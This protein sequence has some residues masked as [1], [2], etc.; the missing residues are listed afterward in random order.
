MKKSLLFSGLI[1]AMTLLCCYALVTADVIHQ[2]RVATTHS[3]LQ[4]KAPAAAT[5]QKV[6]KAAVS[7]PRAGLLSGATKT[8]AL[9]VP[10]AEELDKSPI[11]TRPGSIPTEAILAAN[12]AAVEQAE[13]D[14]VAQKEYIEGLS[15]RIQELKDQGLFDAALWNEYYRAIAPEDQPAGRLDEGGETCATALGI[16]AL[17]YTDTGNTSDNVN[18]YDPGVLTTPNPPFNCPYS[19]STS[20]DVL[21]VYSPTSNICVD[22]NLCYT[23]TLYDTKLYV[24]QDNCGVTGSIVAC[25]DDAC[26]GYVSQI[27]GL[28]L[29]GGHNYYIVVDGYGYSAGAYKITVSQ[30]GGPQP[31]QTCANPVNVTLPPATWPYTNTNTTCGMVNDYSGSTTCLGIYD[32]GEDIIYKLT[33]TQAVTVILSLTSNSSYVG[34]CIDNSCPPDLTCLGLCTTYG[35]G[36]TINNV[37]LAVG[38]YYIMI[39]TWPSPTCIPQFTLTIDQSGGPQP[40]DECA[41][42]IVIPGGERLPYTDTKNTCLYGYTCGMSTAPDLFYKYTVQSP[43]EYLTISL[44]G[45]SYDTYLY[46]WSECCVT[47]LAFNDDY[48]GLQSQ[49]QGCYDP[50][51]IWIEVSGYSSNCG[52]AILNVTSAGPCPEAPPNDD[53]ADATA[54]TLPYVGDGTTAGATDDCAALAGYPSV[55]YTFTLPYACN[56][57]TIEYCNSPIVFN[58]YLI[59][60]TPDC[61]CSMFY[62]GAYAWSCADGNLINRFNGLAAGTYYLPVWVDPPGPFHI[63]IYNV[64]CPA[65]PECPPGSLFSQTPTDAAGAWSFYT[66]D[67]NTYPFWYMCFDNF[68]GLTSYVC[69]LHW[70]GL[71][72]VPIWYECTSENPMTFDI[73]FYQDAA[74][75]PGAQVAAFPGMSVVGQ[76]TGIF[77]SGYQMYYFSTTLTPCVGLAA[78]WVSIQGVSTGSPDCAFLWAN[79]PYG[80]LLSYQFD[81]ATMTNLMDDLAFC[82]TGE[83]ELIGACCD[84]STGDCQ[85][86]V[87]AAA[88]PPPSLFYANTLCAQLDPPCGMGACCDPVTGACT[89]TTQATCSGNWLAGVSCSPNPCPPPGDNCETALQVAVPSSTTGTTVGAD[90]T[91]GLS[92]MDV[93]YWFEMTECRNLTI[94]LCNSPDIYWDSYLMVYAGYGNCCYSYL[95]YDDDGCTPGYWGTSIIASRNYQPGIYYIQVDSYGIS[96]PFVL[97]IVDNGPCPAPP[98]NDLCS[99]AITLVVNDPNPTCGNNGGASGPDCPDYGFPDLWYTF[100]LTEACADLVIEWC[101]TTLSGSLYPYLYDNCDC[102]NAMWCTTYE[103][104]TCPDGLISL[105][106]ANLPAGTYYYPFNTDGVGDFCIRAACAGAPPPDNCMPCEA[107]I[108]MIGCV[109][110]HSYTTCDWNGLPQNCLVGCHPFELNCAGLQYLAGPKIFYMMNL[111]CQTTVDILCT[112]SPTMDPQLMVFTVCPTIGGIED[113]NSCVASSD[114]GAS[115][116]DGMP[117]RIITTIGPGVY[118]LSVDCYQNTGPFACGSYDLHVT[119]TDCPLPVELTTLEAIAGDREVALRWTTASEKDNAS[120]DVQRKT[121]SSEW[122]TVGKVNGVGNSQTPTNYAYTDRAVVNGVAYTYRLISRDINGTT[123]EF[124]TTVE[125]TPGAP[126]PTEYALNQNYPNPFNPQTSITYAVKEAGFVTLKVYNLIGQEVATLVSA[127]MEAGRYTAAFTATDLP[128]GV[129]VYRLEVNDFTAQKKMVLLK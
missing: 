125:A 17:P 39:D 59:V 32:G 110:D 112:P 90:N 103:W 66:S 27:M 10:K 6:D 47:Q 3:L 37:A 102:I 18:D 54:V 1:V 89:Q 2:K 82:L 15:Q 111:A 123:H 93:F 53:C 22:I 74:G 63:N 81:G 106:W 88:C 44:C 12:K 5:I 62:Y 33:V 127:K 129:Y 8:A 80:D 43:N 92:G 107:A 73:A 40:G 120:F 83:G 128:S 60:M 41:N 94:G 65:G 49:V 75:V 26:P 77:Y 14:K 97:D 21:Y 114:T 96:A 52:T 101:G 121:A 64:E 119:S 30:C 11:A 68:W 36:C 58:N 31:G 13:A 34:M 25:N 78:G 57:L 95:Y 70:W 4:T 126:L 71:M 100:T 115:P 45:S 98:V 79:S 55:W 117:E 69:D 28:N 50:G 56:N 23:E 7:D 84:P 91:C 9:P 16:G 86:G 109:Y 85:D 87:P 72:L 99:G 61:E 51:D 48:C 113:C 118:Y 67:N 35:S 104:D 19:G 108:P 42:A 24:Y 116:W 46:V 20:P 122:T 38:T 29:L 124:E 76:P 105:H